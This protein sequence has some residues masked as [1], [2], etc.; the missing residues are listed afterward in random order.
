VSR[1]LSSQWSGPGVRVRDAGH[2]SGRLDRRAA[3]RSPSSGASRSRECGAQC[4]DPTLEIADLWRAVHRS[5]RPDRPLG[6]R[7]PSIRRPWRVRCVAHAI[8]PD[9]LIDVLRRAAQ[10]SDLSSTA[11][12]CAEHRSALRLRH[13]AGN[14]GGRL[15]G[16]CSRTRPG[17]CEPGGT[18]SILGTPE[19]KHELAPV[20]A[21]GGLERPRHAPGRRCA[22]SSGTR[23][24]SSQLP[25]PVPV[26]HAPSGNSRHPGRCRNARMSR[27]SSSAAF[28]ASNVVPGGDMTCMRARVKSPVSSAP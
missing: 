18:G 20:G 24:S 3:Q 27:Q 28:R 9:V 14:R 1:S 13:L 10:R 7:S 11:S 5:D 12:G 19:R 22:A 8:D 16:R 21:G 25:C 2:R 26:V 4:I 17:R 23:S 6:P 15:I